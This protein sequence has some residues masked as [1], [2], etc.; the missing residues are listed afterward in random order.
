MSTTTQ[1]GRIKLMPGTRNSM[2]FYH[3]GVMIHNY[4]GYHLLCPRVHTSRKL[5]LEAE[6]GLEP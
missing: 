4:L 6:P 1:E 2:Q 5:D 3:V